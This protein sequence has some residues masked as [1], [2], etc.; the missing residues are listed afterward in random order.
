MM[1]PF[2]KKT[3]I[4]KALANDAADVNLKNGNLGNNGAVCLA[5]AL[6]A[7]QTLQKINLGRNFIGYEGAG[8]LAE[9]LKVNKT[10]QTMDLWKN[11]IGNEG[12]GKLAEA[13]KVNQTLETIDLGRNSIGSEGVGTLAEALKVN[14][15]LQVIDLSWNSIGNEGA[16]KLAEALKVNQTL[17]ILVLGHNSIGDEGAGKL[18]EALKVNQALQ[19]I[20]LRFNS[21]DA[22]IL[23]QIAFILG[24]SER[25]QTLPNKPTLQQSNFY[26]ELMTMM[27]TSQNI[28][29]HLEQVN[30]LIQDLHM[31]KFFYTAVSSM[32]RAGVLTKE[33]SSSHISASLEK[34]RELCFGAD[35]IADFKL[36]LEKA[37][38]DGHIDR[39][40]MHCLDNKAERNA[41]FNDQRFVSL[42]K[43]V[44]FNT[45]RIEG[46]E[47]NVEA[48]NNSLNAIRKGLKHKMKVE[49]VVG[50]LSATINVVSCGVGGNIMA[51]TASALC[52]IV[53]Y[54]DIV[55]IQSVA[56]KYGDVCVKL[57]EEGVDI[58]SNKY[59]DKKLEEAVKR[60]NLL[61]VVAA[62]AVIMH[63]TAPTQPLEDENF[64][65]AKQKGDAAFR[66]EDFADAIKYYSTAIDEN[67]T[68][69]CLFCNRSV[70]YRKIG[71][72]ENALI[73]ASTA[74]ELD[75]K[76]ARAYYCKGRALHDLKQFDDAHAEFEKGLAISPDDVLLKTGLNQLLTNTEFK[77]HRAVILNEEGNALYCEG[78]FL[79]AVS[80]YSKAID[81]DDSNH[82]LFL[83][84]ACAC[85]ELGDFKLALC[86]AVISIDLDSS[87]PRG[88]Y[89]K[90]RVF[91]S[92]KCLQEAMSA[93]EEGLLKCPTA[94]EL[95][96]ALTLV[97]TEIRLQAFKIDQDGARIFDATGKED[98]NCVPT[99]HMQ[100]ENPKIDKN[101]GDKA[102]S[103]KFRVV[104]GLLL[105][106]LHGV[107]KSDIV[108]Y[109]KC[110]IEDG[111]DTI[112][113]IRTVEEDDLNF[114]KKGHKRVLLKKILEPQNNDA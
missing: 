64:E 49:A 36:L 91:Q 38:S 19:E 5:E 109:S 58:A 111:F 73:D 61:T 60:G 28:E 16:G 53:D 98:K 74:I 96:E 29:S 81:L 100:G 94:V 87:N 93:F 92:M 4:E 13:L 14:Q 31:T 9:A 37:E 6:K 55:H 80:C 50:L 15:T 43:A 62:A 34:S 23:R 66:L 51:A 8:K 103:L 47:A 7:N 90:G 72:A 75:S 110:L 18:V 77:S 44:K 39:R 88:Y 69:S 30:Q 86:D 3:K 56:V 107:D 20:D 82:H 97:K 102:E 24:D 52:S 27:T 89:I 84:R 2:N 67:K 21:I 12:T 22:D 42:M 35:E 70:A 41:V 32:W 25:M 78:H 33:M 76:Y 79:R 104:E 59:A 85:M 40:Q 65:S 1:F 83:G 114:M 57:V 68:S 11:S 95:K 45:A 54:G 112:D 17:Q 10:L 105:T 26:S 101:G 113:A 63:P 48:I 46:L 108:L 71:D 99:S 106:W